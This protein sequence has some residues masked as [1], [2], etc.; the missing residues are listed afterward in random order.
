MPNSSKSE[1]PFAEELSCLPEEFTRALPLS[2]NDLAFRANGN[3]LTS[4]VLF[5]WLSVLLVEAVVFLTPQ[6][7]AFLQ[8]SHGSAA[9][10]VS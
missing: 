4:V 1:V 3:E 9:P 7:P 2:K 5:Q 10:F 6:L 8:A